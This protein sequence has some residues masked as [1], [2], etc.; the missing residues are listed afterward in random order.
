M[1]ITVVGFPRIGRNREWKK[2]LEEYWAKHISQEEFFTQAY[3][4]QKQHLAMM[5]SLDEIPLDFAL[6]DHMLE[7][8]FLL[9]V[10]PENVS[11]LSLSPLDKYFAL[12]RGFQ[13]DTIDIK[14]WPM[15]KWFF[16]NYHYVV[17]KLTPEIC[18][19]PDLSFLSQK[20]QLASEEKKPTRI[21][22]VGPY[23]FYKLSRRENLSETLLRERLLAAYQKLL[24]SH[25]TLLWQLDEP[26]LGM[27]MN[28]HEKEVFSFFY[29][30][31]A[32]SYGKSLHLQTYFGDIRD[33]YQEVISLPIH[34]IGLDFVDGKQNLSLLEQYGFP[35]DKI[36]Y[37][38]ILSGRNIWRSDMTS[39]FRLLNSLCRYT[40]PENIMVS[41]SCSLLHVPYTLE[42]ETL[43]TTVENHFS[44]ALEKIE[45]LKQIASQYNTQ[46]PSDYLQTHSLSPSSSLSPE[47][48]K[49]IESLGDN[50]FNRRL[51]VEE[52]LPLQK[53]L[54]KLPLF[55][56]TTIG[57]FPQTRELRKIRKAY[58]EGNLSHKEYEEHLRHM[59]RECITRQ[60]EIGLDVLVHGE[61][62]RNDMVE[63]FAHFLSGFWT[64]KNGWV[65]SY[66]SRATKPPIIY[67]N[68]KRLKAMTV[69][70]IT[71]AQSLTK[72]PMKAILTGPITIINWS[73]C[74]EDISL[75]EIAYQIALALREEIDE[76]QK[77]SIPIIQVDEAALR[78]KLPLR[79]KD[80]KEYLEIATS[81][82]RLATSGIKPEVQLHT[83]MC[84][85]EF[86]EIADAIEAMDAD[87]LTI[88]AS[89]SDLDVIE[90]L[91][92]YSQKRDIGPGVYDIHSPRIP[93]EEEI[94]TTIQKLLTVIP[95]EHLWI[96]PDCGLK[97]RQEHE[98][99]ESLSHMVKA[100]QK[101]RS[102]LP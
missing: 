31:L 10:I 30:Q 18:W 25:A 9:G 87:V 44:F 70:W 92:T 15:K 102:T 5:S 101:L 41:T 13:S 73:F 96:N 3:A 19:T 26:A 69:P 76:L 74:R 39:L 83:H 68:I 88:E 89:R 23:T 50:A 4:L 81:A 93:S 72:K 33:I 84:Y 53:Q 94:S 11:S 56:T 98:A 46:S 71:Y 60:E 63:Y 49:T 64:T 77:E 17:P 54:L 97:T 1:R 66:G 52:R 29:Q 24:N 40:K 42:G 86:S 47:L 85:S 91:R 21:T 2:A 38:G 22:L 37:A 51:P 48:Q 34:S 43:P 6:Y 65:Q 55:P 79:K 58:Q 95:A 14:A 99:Y 62:E 90:S 8:C 32:P 61:Y 59:I 82:F 36:L 45:E 67:G 78:E 80:W 57:S 7:T 35:A 28:A 20:I 100:A 12:A 16:T 75:R 27:D